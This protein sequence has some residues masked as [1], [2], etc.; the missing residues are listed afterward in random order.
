MRALIALPAVALLGVAVWLWGFGGADRVAFWAASGQREAQD[1]MAGALRALK[2][3]DL[4]AVWGLWGVAFAYGVVHAAG[5][6][7]GKLVIGGVG[8]GSRVPVGRLSLLALGGSLAQTASAVVLVY[9]GVLLLG[10]SR[11]YMQGLADRVMAPL[12]Y[13]LIGLVGLWL[14]WRGLRHW[15]RAGGV[16]DHAHHGEGETCDHCGHAHG[17]SLQQAQDT[18]SLW[19]ALA[20]I[21][22]I[23]IRPCTGALFLLILCWRIGADW[24]G[25]IG[26]FA[27]GLGTATITVVV[28][29]AAV[30]FRESALAQVAASR[31]AARAMAGAEVLAG[32]V[33]AVLALQLVLQVI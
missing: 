22:T 11:T 14:V 31:G 6:G 23:G 2:A 10:W 27:M 1:A 30:G 5:P 28:A 19:D 16:A 25:I 26:A 9:A 20:V 24:A 13:G 12:S 32:A 33:V 18:R 29:I 21:G 3:G 7:H 17:P 15:R 8:V 4:A